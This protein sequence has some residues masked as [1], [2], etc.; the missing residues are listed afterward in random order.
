[1]DIAQVSNGYVYHTIF[2]NYAAVPRDSL[3]NTGEN[4]L[5]LVRAFANASEL[6]D[7]EVITFNLLHF[8]CT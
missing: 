7:I 8:R 2:D 3:Q 1:L 6:Y 5:P 4:V